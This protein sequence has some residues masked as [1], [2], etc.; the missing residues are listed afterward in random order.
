MIIHPSRNIDAMSTREPQSPGLVT[1]LS[2]EPSP[3]VSASATVMC[4][5]GRGTP[6]PVRPDP[7][8]GARL[9]LAKPLCNRRK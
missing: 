1:S 4:R 5:S 9:E 2:G 7:A 8:H 3:S 6:D